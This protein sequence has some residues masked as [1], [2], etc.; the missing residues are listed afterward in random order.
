MRAFDAEL[1]AA[2]LRPG[3]LDDLRW[4]GVAG[5]LLAAGDAGSPATGE[6]VRRAWEALCGPALARLRRAGLAGFA[7]LGIHPRSIPWR[8]LEA[9]LAALPEYLGRRG[10]VALGA[11]GLELGGEREEEVLARQLALAR[12]LRLPVV[13][14]TPWRD[15]ERLT[16]RVLALLREAELEPRRVLVGRVDHRTVR[17]VRA[18]GFGAGLSLSAG[19]D[20]GL[21]EAVALVRSLGPEGLVLGSGAGDGAGDLLA[22]PRAAGRLAKAGL[23]AAVIRRVCGGN[24][25]RLLG[26]EPERLSAGAGR[27]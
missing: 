6:A 22:L 17:M 9:L 11:V 19:R 3:D 5:A 25:L 20:D 10:V 12:D 27:G 2:A 7:A 18:C 8:G 26:I 16:R 14:H 1:H 21:S 13:V 24:A 15:K 23:S 4:F